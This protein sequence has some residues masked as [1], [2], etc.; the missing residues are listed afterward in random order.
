MGKDFPEIPVTVTFKDIATSDALEVRIRELAQRLARFHSRITVCRVVVAEAHR[1]HNKGT[2]HH[3]RIDLTVPDGEIVVNREPEE[4]HAHEDAY[5]AVRDAFEAAQ[6]QLRDWVGRHAKH[7]A[8]AHPTPRHGTV[9][10]VFGDDGFGF[11]ETPDGD[12]VYF[13][14]NAVTHGGWDK[15]DVGTYVRF[16]EANGDKG[17]HATNVTLVDES[18]GEFVEVRE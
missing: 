14:K 13:H 1:Q 4:N 12:E 9:V 7:G 6:R 17:P 3:V 15:L 16:I 18:E 5:I 2:L 10:R 11:I 8:K